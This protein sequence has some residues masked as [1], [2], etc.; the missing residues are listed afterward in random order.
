VAN[1]YV[2]SKIVCTY[3]PQLSLA[4]CKLSFVSQFKYLRHIIENKFCDDNNI[5]REIKS[6]FSRANVLIRRFLYC[7]R[8]VKL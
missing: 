3:F 1:P 7:S 4:N 8:Q 5:N 6:L 2:R